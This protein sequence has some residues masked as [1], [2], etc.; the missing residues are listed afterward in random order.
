ALPQGAEESGRRPAGGL[1]EASGSAGG[2]PRRS[3]GGSAGGRQ[4]RITKPMGGTIMKDGIRFAP[5]FSRRTLLAGGA[6]LLAGALAAKAGHAATT[7][8][9]M[10]WQGYDDPLKAGSFLADNGIDLATTYINANEEII[11]KLQAGGGGQLDLA[12]IY[13]GHVPILTAADL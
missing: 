12:T 8:T 1:D 3:A 5:G 10:G 4:E 13:F 11:T 2:V 9:W 7:V 6:V